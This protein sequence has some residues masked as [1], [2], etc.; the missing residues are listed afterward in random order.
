MFSMGL[1]VR[2]H[3][4]RA[5]SNFSVNCDY[6]TNVGAQVSGSSRLSRRQV[7][8]VACLEK[9]HIYPGL[10]CARNRE[11]YAMAGCAES[12]KHFVSGY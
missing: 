10:A 4:A 8:S 3:S 5:V 1:E 6:V 7:T 11:M 12:R 9:P 2:A